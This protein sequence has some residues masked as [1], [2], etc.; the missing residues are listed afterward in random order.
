MNET[1]SGPATGRDDDSRET[2]D[3][4]DESA[5]SEELEEHDIPALPEAEPADGPAPAA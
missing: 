4:Q 2:L 3:Q 5:V 1:S